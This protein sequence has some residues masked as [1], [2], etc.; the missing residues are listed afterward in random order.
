MG[1]QYSWL[2]RERVLKGVANEILQFPGSSKLILTELADTENT[3]GTSLLTHMVKNICP[4]CRRA[5]FNPSVWKLPWS[6]E[7]VPTPVFLPGEFHGQKSL[8]DLMGVQ[9]Q[10]RLS[11]SHFREQGQG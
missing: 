5:R 3:A 9:S 2:K 4:Q 11:D 6:R 1:K 7:W 10:T 8:A